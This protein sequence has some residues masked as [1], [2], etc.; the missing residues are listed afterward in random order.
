MSFTL[1]LD[2]EQVRIEIRKRHPKL[3]LWIDGQ[4][5]V[6]GPDAGSVSGTQLLDID[7]RAVRFTRAG[8]DDRCMIRLA[9]RT[10]E[11]TL[12][13][14]SALGRAADDHG[15]EV[16]A[17]MPGTV[18]SIHKSAGNI[19]SRGD[20]LLTIESMK[21]QMALSAPRDGVVAEIL[22]QEGE[23]FDKDDIVARLVDKNRNG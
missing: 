10:F 7:G 5:H 8:T 2:G 16:R 18:V 15:S 6:V 19:I 3:V 13:D 12:P 9:G 22:R 20:A 17:P 1:N 21:L 14:A 23:R 11:L 4:E